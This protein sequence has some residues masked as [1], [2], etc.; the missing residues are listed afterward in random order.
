MPRQTQGV[1]RELDATEQPRQIGPAEEADEDVALTE[2]GMRRR[3]QHSEA[4]S[5]EEQH[6]H[7]GHPITGVHLQ[8][9]PQ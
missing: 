4:G 1:L 6:A 8:G 2:I 3:Q 5:Q 7:S 9:A